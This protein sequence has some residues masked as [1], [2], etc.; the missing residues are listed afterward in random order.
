MILKAQATRRTL[1]VLAVVTVTLLIAPAQAKA[2]RPSDAAGAGTTFT[3]THG[4][5][6]M[7]IP[8]AWRSS[9]KHT[10]PKR[11]HGKYRVH[12]GR[13]RPVQ[14]KDLTLY[15]DLVSNKGQ[16]LRDAFLERGKRGG[17]ILRRGFWQTG[18]NVKGVELLYDVRHE[19]SGFWDGHQ[20]WLDH[21]N[22]GSPGDHDCFKI[23]QFPGFDVGV[24]GCYARG[25]ETDIGTPYI[26]Y[27]CRFEV[28]TL[29]R[30]FGIAVQYNMHV[31][32]HASGRLTFWWGDHKRLDLPA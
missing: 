31:N 17:T 32:L 6:P 14:R 10:H 5:T 11:C 20:V 23:H 15:G 22:D 7:R 8:C 24:N 13:A 1:A 30:G 21:P 19:G 9:R 26:Q 4:K 2:Q 29:W 27:W 12:A 16:T 18:I 28:A 3:R 25:R